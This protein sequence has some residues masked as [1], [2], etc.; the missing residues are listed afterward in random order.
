MYPESAERTLLADWQARRERLATRPAP[1]GQLGGLHIQI[2]DYLIGRYADSPEA[3]RPARF[4]PKSDLYVNDRAIVVHHHLWQGKVS[5]VKSRQEAETR[6]S[7]VLKQLI[8]LGEDRAAETP[9]EPLFDADYRLSPEPVPS[10]LWNKMVWAIR[11]RRK[12]H[13]AIEAALKRSPFLPIE[14]LRYLYQRLADPALE[15]RCALD[16]LARCENRNAP[17]YCYYA[18]RK[19]LEAGKRDGITDALERLSR[20][21]GADQERRR[22]IREQIAQKCRA[23][24]ASNDPAARLKAIDILGRIGTLDDIGLLSDLLCLPPLKDEHPEERAAL[25]RA[26]QQ[27]S[28]AE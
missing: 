4:S 6:V 3:A 20:R 23:E 12:A 22:R 13:S 28:Q 14:A 2:L 8:S 26:M 21:P 15:D 9:S 7:A 18:W 1:V 16:L 27:I 10:N 11:L 5:G 19:R 17:D 24:L 25:A